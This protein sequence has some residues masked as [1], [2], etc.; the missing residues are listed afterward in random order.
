MAAFMPLFA[1]ATSNTSTGYPIVYKTQIIFNAKY[2]A[3]LSKLENSVANGAS[4]GY[5]PRGATR[6]SA[7]AHE[8]GHYISY[9]AMLNYY[10]TQG[11][12]LT[13]Q[14]Q[15]DVLYKVYRDFNSGDF[16]YK[17]LQEA[18]SKYHGNKSFD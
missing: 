10:Q 5:F 7:V 12:V 14:S 11:F 1:I 6:S 4:S 3:D 9:V 2:F 16:S 17:V 15:S 18:Y 13:R 8:F